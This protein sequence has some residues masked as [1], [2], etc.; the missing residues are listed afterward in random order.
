VT[1]KQVFTLA[2]VAILA[3]T[4]FAITLQLTG[5]PGEAM[6]LVEAAGGTIGTV[7]VAWMFLR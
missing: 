3:V 6:R 7:F 4:A 1:N 2:I 5:Q